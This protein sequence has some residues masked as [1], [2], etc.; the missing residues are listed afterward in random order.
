MERKGLAYKQLWL[1]KYK[2]VKNEMAG[3]PIIYP[4]ISQTQEDNFSLNSFVSKNR[5][6]PEP[7][8][9]NV[10][11]VKLKNSAGHYLTLQDVKYS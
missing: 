5:F 8:R 1:F 7:G 3:A 10:T 4:E 2:L 6:L 11:S 9:M